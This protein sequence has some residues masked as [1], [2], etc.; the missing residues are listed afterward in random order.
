MGLTAAAAAA[1]RE[2]ADDELHPALLAAQP[3]SAFFRTTGR[4][5]TELGHMTHLKKIDLDENAV[6]SSVPSELGLLV[7]LTVLSL[8]KNAITG[9][10]PT[11]LCARYDTVGP[12]RRPCAPRSALTPSAARAALGAAARRC[13][14]SHLQ[15]KARAAAGAAP[16]QERAQWHRHKYAA[17]HAQ[18]TTAV[19]SRP[20]PRMAA[21]PVLM[22]IGRPPATA[23]TDDSAAAA[24]S[25]AYHV[26][27]RFARRTTHP[28]RPQPSSASSA[29]WACSS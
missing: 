6:T 26:A 12:A 7:A 23:P 20:A 24:R 19:G 1:A 25:P 18:P 8:S 9:T 29:T 27:P 21:H 14:R 10:I 13:D 17:R 22:R 4:I 15:G 2:H 5:P 28:P 11:E 3:V 16:R